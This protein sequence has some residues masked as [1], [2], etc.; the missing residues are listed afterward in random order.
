[1]YR[2]PTIFRW[3]CISYN[4]S[5]DCLIDIVYGV[6]NGTKASVTWDGRSEGMTYEWY[7]VVDDGI[8][9]TQSLTWVFTI[10]NSTMIDE[11]MGIC[12]FTINTNTDDFE[13]NFSIAVESE[14]LLTF[15]GAIK[16]PTNTTLGDGLLFINITLDPSDNLDGLLNLTIKYNVIKYENIKIWY[17]NES[18]ND[19]RGE[20]QELDFND[21]GNGLIKISLDHASVFAITGIIVEEVVSFSWKW[22]G[23]WNFDFDFTKSTPPSK[24][25]PPPL[26]MFIIIGTSIAGGLGGSGIAIF[27]K[28]KRKLMEM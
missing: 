27:I 15:A 22:N 8:T 24:V 3:M 1:M 7:V 21:L 12:N 17:F 25:E 5:D 19:G 16:N 9:T 10:A 18:A 14:T 11:S 4:A 23:K 28:K 6:L 20:W 26:V 13:V 2:I